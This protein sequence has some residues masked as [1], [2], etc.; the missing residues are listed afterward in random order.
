MAQIHDHTISLWQARTVKKIM[1]PMRATFKPATN[2]QSSKIAE[3]PISTRPSTGLLDALTL[4]TSSIFRLGLSRSQLEAKGVVTNAL[5]QLV[6]DCLSLVDVDSLVVGKPTSQLVWDVIF[7]EEICQDAAL[8]V[9][10]QQI[11]ESLS[12]R[13]CLPCMLHLYILTPSTARTSRRFQKRPESA[14]QDERGRPGRYPTCSSHAFASFP[15]RE[16]SRDGQ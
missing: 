11:R 3:I 15:E 8:D 14:K 1:Q 5:K 12:D 4:L 9:S 13:V 10:F 16:S 2:I 7:L 6:T